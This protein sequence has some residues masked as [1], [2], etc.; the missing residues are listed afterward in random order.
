MG[1]DSTLR[2]G[3]VDGLGL[4]LPAIIAATKTTAAGTRDD[5]DDCPTSSQMCTFFLLTY[6]VFGPIP[7]QLYGSLSKRHISCKKNK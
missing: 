5:H 1:S 7:R 2:G 6:F 4:R 3:V